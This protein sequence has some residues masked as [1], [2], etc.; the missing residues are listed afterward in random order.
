M[1]VFLCILLAVMLSGCALKPLDTLRREQFEQL[2]RKYS[3]F[4]FKLAWDS[5]V[6]NNGVTVEGIIW[7]VRW[8]HA[9]GLAISV[10]LLDP[11]GRVLATE[12]DLISPDPLNIQEKSNFS[13]TLP[14]KPVPGS[15][16]SFTY[17]YYAVEDQENSA[18]WMQGFEVDL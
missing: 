17:R 5:K 3:Q 12:T 1:R 4:D 13:V 7:N 2:P 16:L 10:S 8:L 15:K 6:T 14:A 18:Y 9:E 11:E